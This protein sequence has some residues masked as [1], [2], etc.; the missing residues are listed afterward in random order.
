MCTSL[1]TYSL[2]LPSKQEFKHGLPCEHV[3]FVFRSREAFLNIYLRDCVFTE[4]KAQIYLEKYE[5]FFPVFYK[6]ALMQLYIATSFS[7]VHS[8]CMVSY[9]SINSYS[10]YNMSTEKNKRYTELSFHCKQGYIFSS[11]KK[12]IQKLCSVLIFKCKVVF[13]FLSAFLT[14]RRVGDTGENVLLCTTVGCVVPGQEDLPRLETEKV[15]WNF[16]RLSFLLLHYV[17]KILV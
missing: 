1:V 12:K 3:V 2:Q 9:N 11:S 8:L 15:H 17:E 6:V 14:C 5:L 16:K 13:P 7:H 4:E 10:R